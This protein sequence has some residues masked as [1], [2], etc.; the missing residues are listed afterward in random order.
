MCIKVDQSTR[1]P[2][3]K[4]QRK[5]LLGRLRPLTHYDENLQEW[6]ALERL[7]GSYPIALT[8]HLPRSFG[9]VDTDQGIA[10]SMELVR[11]DDGL[12]SETI[13]R[14]LWVHGCDAQLTAALDE[15][16][17]N[18]LQAA[19]MTRELLPHNLLLRRQAAGASIVLVDGFG[20]PGRFMLPRLLRRR[21]AAA[22][23]RGLDARIELVLQRRREGQD[24]KE[25]IGHLQRDL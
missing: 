11:D 18:W 15:F 16:R 21:R 10:H 20:R 14:Y 19:P 24:P 23:L 2:A 3:L 5:G 25:R 7:H 8:R 13:E 4:R 12:I 1:T 6:R 22:R 17:R 9:L